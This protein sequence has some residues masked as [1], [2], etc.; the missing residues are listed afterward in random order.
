[1]SLDSSSSLLEPLTE[2]RL[3][4]SP[5]CPGLEASASC[6]LWSL[7]VHSLENCFEAKSKGGSA[8][9]FP[10]NPHPGVLVRQWL[11]QEFG[12]PES[13]VQ[14]LS[15][16]RTKRSE[17][18]LTVVC[19]FCRRAAPSTGIAFSLSSGILLRRKWTPCLPHN[20]V[21]PLKLAKGTDSLGL[22]PVKS[23]LDKLVFQSAEFR[24][25][26]R[27]QDRAETDTRMPCRR[28]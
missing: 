15:K 20:A 1:M 7:Q 22:L 3:A 5:L 17:S 10:Q 13:R 16:S 26:F 6:D 14:L 19:G 12:I 28:S 8:K 11:A 27:T 21:R 18:E 9:L 2:V 24:S 25:D 4:A 23:W